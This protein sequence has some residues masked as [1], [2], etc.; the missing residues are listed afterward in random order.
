[1]RRAITWARTRHMRALR[2]SKERARMAED[3]KRSHT[4]ADH[5]LGQDVVHEHDGDADHDHDHFEFDSD[6]RLEENPIWIQD[7]VTLVTVGIDIGSSRPPGIFFPL[8]LRRLGPD[9][10]NPY[11]LLSRETPFQP[12]VG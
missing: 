10:T 9:L 12:P 11:Y 8:N 1:M 5:L 7:H 2:R 6:E 4:V 3:R